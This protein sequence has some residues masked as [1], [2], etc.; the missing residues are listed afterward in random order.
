[1]DKNEFWKIINDARETAGRW[2]DMYQPLVDDLTRLESGEIMKWQLIFEEYQG[3]SYKEKLWGAAMVMMN[4]CSDDNFDY[5]RGWLTAQGRDV[6]LGALADPDSLAD[7]EAVKIFAREVLSSEYTPLSGY[8][9]TPRFES[10]LSVAADAYESKP[11]N[12]DF[13]HAL[14][15]FSL[16]ESEKAALIGEIRYAEDMDIKLGGIGAPWHETQVKLEEV[17]PRLSGLYQPDERESVLDK[18]REGKKDIP[19]R[20]SKINRH[21]KSGPER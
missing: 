21:K 20:E 13:Y 9:N 6:F 3:L 19:P 16:S 17:L 18:L 1:M 10:V 15:G 8:Q 12:G 11:G 2:Q 5:F 7:V 4:G 14:E